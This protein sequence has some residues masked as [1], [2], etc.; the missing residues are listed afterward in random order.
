MLLK[1]HPVEPAMAFVFRG[2]YLPLG[3]GER[4]SLP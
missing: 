3:F 1:G 2:L 4:D